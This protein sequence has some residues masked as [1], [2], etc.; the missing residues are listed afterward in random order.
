MPA[1]PL[2]TVQQSILPTSCRPTNPYVLACNKC[3][4]GGYV[5][6][7]AHKLTV[8]SI[9]T[10]ATDSH[11]QA[12]GTTREEV[13]TTASYGVSSSMQ[14]TLSQPFMHKPDPLITTAE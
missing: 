11:V 13:K 10:C 7:F 12:S 1:T 8:T 4:G 3:G 2:A 5:S 9:T 6:A 14:A